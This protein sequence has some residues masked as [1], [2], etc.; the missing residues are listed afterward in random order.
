MLSAKNKRL[1]WVLLPLIALWLLGCQPLPASAPVPSPQPLLIQAGAIFEPL[2]PLMASCS[3]PGTMLVYTDQA[4][5][6][7]VRLRWGG[8]IGAE[9]FSFLLSEQALVL[10]VHP[11]NPIQALTVEHVRALLSGD[12]QNWKQAGG[13]DLAVR[14]W[15]YPP[16]DPAR[17]WIDEALEL[18]QP[19]AGTSNI[20]PGPAQ[21][22]EAIARD[23][24]SAGF[25]PAWWL[26]GTLKAAPVAADMPLQLSR[27]LTAE[28]MSQPQGVVKTWLLCL[29]EGLKAR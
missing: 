24:A 25:L 15:S 6:A 23:P 7:A 3:P 29:Q 17:A 26:D 2:Y 10:A 19:A 16:G 8:Q 22:R 14:A 1:V 9:P 27:P 13:P 5:Q 21:M 4:S 11:Q 18:T 12:M 20:A 28:T